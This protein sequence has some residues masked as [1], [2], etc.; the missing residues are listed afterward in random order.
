MLFNQYEFKTVIELKRLILKEKQRFIRGF[1]SHLMTYALGREL[2]PADSLALDDITARAMAGKDQMRTGLEGIAMSDPFLHKNTLGPAPA[3][4]RRSGS[5][6][7][8]E[9]AHGSSQ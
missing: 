3:R 9:N 6:R 2:G 7:P 8:S 5:Q 4:K 1:V